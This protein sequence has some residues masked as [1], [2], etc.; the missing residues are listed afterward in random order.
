VFQVIKNSSSGLFEARCPSGMRL[1]SCSLGN[2]QTVAND[3]SRSANT[4][5]S[6]NCI[7]ND[8]HGAQCIAWCTNLPIPNFEIIVTEGIGNFFANCTSGKQV[9]GC[10]AF[11]SPASTD[12]WTYPVADGSSCECNET[13]RANCYASC[14]SNITNYEIVSTIGFGLVTATCTHPDNVV[15]GCGSKGTTLISD[16]WR[17][18]HPMSNTSCTCSNANGTKCYA[19]CGRFW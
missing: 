8:I 6:T 3:K 13:L 7:C 18:S 4:Q 12:K 5:Y 11:S 16:P 14:A 10:T 9:M 15:L 19:I 1:L 17:F 2:T